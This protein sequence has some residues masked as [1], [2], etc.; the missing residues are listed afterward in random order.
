MPTTP[1]RSPMH[2]MID[3][4]TMGTT[5]GCPILSI[6]AVTF[7]ANGV[8]E[9][10]F[11][12]AI[13]LPDNPTVSA[14]TLLWWL[15]QSEEARHTLIDDQEAALSVEEALKSFYTW[16]DESLRDAW[17]GG[18]W[19]NGASFDLPIIEHAMRDVGVDV[20]WPFYMHRCFRT[21]KSLPGADAA[22]VKPE[23]EGTAHNAL[24]DAI[25]QAEWL[26]NIHH[27]ITPCL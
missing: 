13:K 16:V 22:G 23:F 5:P 9:N 27:K 11:Y 4:E 20:P 19:A 25:H 3:L 6:G 7:D 15:N 18:V 21:M 26:I 24:D 14:S 8:R 1:A 17:V 10:P 12:S 2:I